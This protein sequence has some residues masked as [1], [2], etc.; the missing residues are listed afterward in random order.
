[1][2]DLFTAKILMV[3]DHPENLFALQVILNDENY[4]CVKVSSGRAA[5][6]IVEKDTDFALILMDVQMPGMDGFETVE[7]IRRIEA[8]RHVSVIFLTANSDN[9]HM[10]K[11][12]EV[13][14]VDYLIKPLH[15]EILK[16]KIAVFV[17]L[18]L[19]T[20]ALKKQEEEM[21]LVLN[22]LKAANSTLAI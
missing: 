10:F 16:A 5:I 12:Y 18:H 19:K 9:I 22:Q 1:M 13:G 21:N 2:S 11:G 14:A 3:D 4:E 17:D 8:M 6:N 15:P 7:H 20:K